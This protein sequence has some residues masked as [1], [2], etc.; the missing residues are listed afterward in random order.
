MEDKFHIAD[1]I[2][3]K[4]RGVISAEE[5][6]ELDLWISKSPQNEEVYKRA[7]DSGIQRSKME[8]YRL[9]DKDKVWSALE[10]EL[11]Q[12][13]TR[14]LQP[15]RILRY[16]AAII[17]P[18]VMVGAIAYYFSTN[19][20]ESTFALLDEDIKPGTTKAVLI[21]SDG[22]TLD[23]EK[24]AAIQSIEEGSSRI[25][26]TD[27]VLSYSINDDI[28]GGEL[29]YNELR[30]PV[31]GKYR[32]N[33]TDGTA[34]WLNTGSSLKFPVSFTDSTREVF[35]EGEAFF[36][37]AHNGKPF[38]VHSPEMDVRVLGTS[39]NVKA[40]TDGANYK[41]TLV[42]GSVKL[43]ISGQNSGE[44][45]EKL[46]KPND[47]LTWDRSTS[48]ISV[49]SV[50]TSYYTSWMQGKIEFDNENLDMVMLTLSRW[51]D[52]SY[53]FKN[54]QAKNYHF[55]ARLDQDEKISSILE[56]LEMTTDVKF[57]YKD[58]SIIIL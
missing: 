55:S 39:F 22:N 32:L 28:A 10:D 17:M 50:N 21:L 6:A 58:G 37:V 23:L 11:F 12:T 4:I 49:S 26:N 36:D 30:T 19:R 8:V 54:Q 33:L 5:Q 1:L 40:Y 52:F 13:K 51:Y 2:V 48:E 31:G 41:T 38:I 7:K 27:N 56:M 15:Q 14:R 47:Q 9:F 46:L 43:E 34:V 29:I 35:L 45:M 18:L 16:A 44:K 42:E 24:V 20:T 25:S 53:T 3:K 57:E